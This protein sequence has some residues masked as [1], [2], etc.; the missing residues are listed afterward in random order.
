MSVYSCPNLGHTASTSRGGTFCQLATSGEREGG[1]PSN[2]RGSPAFC[3][4]VQ[5]AVSPTPNC[6]TLERER[7]QEHL[8]ASGRS[9]RMLWGLSVG[10][11]SVADCDQQGALGTPPER[12]SE[13]GHHG[14]APSTSRVWG[15]RG[16]PGRS[17]TPRRAR[18]RR[19]TPRSDASLAPPQISRSGG[20]G[21]PWAAA[22]GACRA[23]IRG[24]GRAQ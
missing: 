7:P 2:D 17:S 11:G 10:C 6:G 20:S 23:A 22:A 8:A 24:P 15:R 14:P 13:A 21:G 12:R 16:R 3:V 19:R 9:A 1:R 4:P 18:R 5:T